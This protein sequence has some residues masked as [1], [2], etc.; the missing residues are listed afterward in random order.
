MVNI[1]P[2]NDELFAILLSAFTDVELSD[3]VKRFR[4]NSGYLLLIGE[5]RKEYVGRRMSAERIADESAETITN[6]VHAAESLAGDL[7]VAVGQEI[8]GICRLH[9]RL[10]TVPGKDSL[11]WPMI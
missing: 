3:K 1:L 9:N 7:I 4:K 6:T 5:P 10:G 11:Q 2:F 8:S